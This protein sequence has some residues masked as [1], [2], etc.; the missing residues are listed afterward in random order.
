[1]TSI[2]TREVILA[3]R[4]LRTMEE[5]SP[6]EEERE[7]IRQVLTALGGR[8]ARRS[9]LPGQPQSGPGLGYRIAFL[10]PP[11]YRVDAGRFSIQYRFDDEHIYVGF[12]GVY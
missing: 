11:T 7:A 6:T 2:R 3:P 9:L 10:E 8:G 5:F 12:I 1:M 4:A